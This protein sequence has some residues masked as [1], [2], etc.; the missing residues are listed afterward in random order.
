LDDFLNVARRSGD[1]FLVR[2]HEFIPGHRDVQCAWAAQRHSEVQL[3]VN[4][5][6]F[7]VSAMVQGPW[8]YYDN[9]GNCLTIGTKCFANRIGW[10]CFPRWT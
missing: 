10:A 5:C 4:L 9:S 3:A 6:A 7:F 8:A 2:T 1:L